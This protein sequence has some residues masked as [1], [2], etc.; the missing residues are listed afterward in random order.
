MPSRGGKT[1]QRNSLL[2]TIDGIVGL[3]PLCTDSHVQL[4]QRQRRFFIFC[5][6]KKHARMHDTI[7]SQVVENSCS[8]P[9]AVSVVAQFSLHVVRVDSQLATQ[10]GGDH[11]SCVDPC[12]SAR[13]SCH[14]SIVTSHIGHRL[15]RQVTSWVGQK[16]RMI[17]SLQI[18]LGRPSVCKLFTGMLHEPQFSDCW[19]PQKALSGVLSCWIGA[20]L[21]LSFLI[22]DVF[23]C[24]RI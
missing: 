3:T 18:T 10:S 12:K 17:A 24:D 13:D 16:L 2:W 23:C 1:L 19:P 22:L 4:L 5:G 6:L 20:L 9:E 14:A 11:E 15:L 7:A 8:L 21:S